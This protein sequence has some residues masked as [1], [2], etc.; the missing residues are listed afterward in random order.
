M[1]QSLKY[2]RWAARGEAFSVG[3]KGKNDEFDTPVI[4]HFLGRFL[5]FQKKYSIINGIQ[6]VYQ[7]VNLLPFVLAQAYPF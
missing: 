7:R 3:L 1:G 6:S 2:I 4:V 5:G